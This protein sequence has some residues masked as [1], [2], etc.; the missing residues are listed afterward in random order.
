MCFSSIGRSISESQPWA[1]VRGDSNHGQRA[2]ALPERIVKA[3][4]DKN[5]EIACRLRQD[6]ERAENVLARS[7]PFRAIMMHGRGNQ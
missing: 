4:K 7:L 1:A 2:E 3:R 6:G 5:S